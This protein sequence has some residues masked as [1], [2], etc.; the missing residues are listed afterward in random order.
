[1]SNKLKQWVQTFSPG[2]WQITGEVP[3]HYQPRFSLAQKK[4]LSQGPQFILK[5]FVDNKWK[6]SFETASAHSSLIKKLTKANHKKLEA[7]MAK[8]PEWIDDFEAYDSPISNLL[9]VGFALERKSDLKK[10]KAEINSAIAD[11]L[12]SGMT[13]DAILKAIAASSFSDH[14][15]EVPQSATLQ[16][17]NTNFEI[18]RKNLIYRKMNVLNF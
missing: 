13:S 6:P 12:K 14:C 10:L 7:L 15:G 11:N 5:R 8:N 2:V 3:E 16:F 9:N 17:E 18:R 1:M 4:E